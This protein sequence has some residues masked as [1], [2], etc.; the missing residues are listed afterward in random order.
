MS[1]GVFNNMRQ[2]KLAADA[3]YRI[4]KSTANGADPSRYLPARPRGCSAR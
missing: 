3:I 4:S 2:M 1:I